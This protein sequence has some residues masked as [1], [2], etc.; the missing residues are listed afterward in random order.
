[1]Y[2]PFLSY[3]VKCGYVELDVTDRQNAHGM[4]IAAR[5]IIDLYQLVKR[6]RGLNQKILGISIYRNVHIYGHFAVIHTTKE[7]RTVGKEIQ[8]IGD[9]TRI[10]HHRR[11]VLGIDLHS[12]NGKDGW[13]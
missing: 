10:T 6:E 7:A 5:A 8:T 11:H 4:D 13:R 1:M 9:N 12:G 2:L 3:E